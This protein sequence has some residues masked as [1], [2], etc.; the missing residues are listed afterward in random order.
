MKLPKL[1][2]ALA[3][4]SLL[5]FGCSSG[6]GPTPEDEQHE[7]SQAIGE[8]S[9]GTLSNPQEWFNGSIPDPGVVSPATYSHSKCYKAFVTRIFGLTDFRSDIVVADARV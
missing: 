6:D 2:L 8:A 1:V 3:L 9:C 5:A 7:T 4:P